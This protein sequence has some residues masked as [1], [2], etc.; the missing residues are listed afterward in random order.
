MARALPLSLYDPW[1]ERIQMSQSVLKDYSLWKEF[2]I[3]YIEK[4]SQTAGNNRKYEQ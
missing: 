3:K 1:T 4:K 2:K